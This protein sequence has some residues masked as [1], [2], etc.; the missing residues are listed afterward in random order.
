MQ[1]IEEMR[2]ERDIPIVIVGDF[3]V[4]AKDRL[5]RG[6]EEEYKSAYDPYP[7]FTIYRA[8]D[9]GRIPDELSDYIFF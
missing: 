5:I 3:N 6:L 1:V 7:R 4:K 2:A 9:N 8:R